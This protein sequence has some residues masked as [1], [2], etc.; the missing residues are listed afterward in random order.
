MDNEKYENNEQ[1]SLEG[2]YKLAVSEMNNAV[3]EADYLR[4]ATRFYGLH[5]Y[6]D[7]EEREWRCRRRAEKIRNDGLLESAK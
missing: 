7:S 5:G 4:V 3:Y 6:R 1:N 2:L